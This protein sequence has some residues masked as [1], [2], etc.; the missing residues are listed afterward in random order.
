MAIFKRYKINN[1]KE[2][3]IDQ[4]SGQISDGGL[5]TV[6]I[7]EEFGGIV[8]NSILIGEVI[9]STLDTN[10]SISEINATTQQE[11]D[12]IVRLGKIP[13]RKYISI[14]DR[15]LGW[16]E[17]A[18]TRPSFFY[19][20]CEPTKFIRKKPVSEHFFDFSTFAFGTNI[21][22]GSSPMDRSDDHSIGALSLQ[23]IGTFDPNISN[24]MGV[25]GPRFNQMDLQLYMRMVI[26]NTITIGQGSIQNDQGESRP[27]KGWQPL[28]GVILENIQLLVSNKSENFDNKNNI[29]DSLGRY[30]SYFNRNILDGFKASNYFN[31]VTGFTDF[32]QSIGSCEETT[33]TSISTNTT[34][35]ITPIGDV[36]ETGYTEEWDFIIN[37]NKNQLEPI[38][39]RSEPVKPS[40][41]PKA[42]YDFEDINP[43]FGSD[44]DSFFTLGTLTRLSYQ[45]KGSLQGWKDPREPINDN[46]DSPMG[47]IH[48]GINQRTKGLVF[49]PA[50]LEE[51]IDPVIPFEIGPTRKSLSDIYRRN[52][53]RM[54]S[55]YENEYVDPKIGP[56]YGNKYLM[57]VIGYDSNGN[58]H[59]SDSKTF[60]EKLIF[61]SYNKSFENTIVF[62]LRDLQKLDKKPMYFGFFTKTLDFF[63][64]DLGKLQFDDTIYRDIADIPVTFASKSGKYQYSSLAEKTMLLGFY[65]KFPISG[66]EMGESVSIKNDSDKRIQYSGDKDELTP[67]PS[68][69]RDSFGRKVFSQLDDVYPTQSNK[70]DFNVDFMNVL[71][72]DIYKDDI[73]IK[74]V[75]IQNTTLLSR[76]TLNLSVPIVARRSELYGPNPLQ[77][78]LYADMINWNTNLVEYNI[79]ENIARWEPRLDYITK[80]FRR[81]VSQECNQFIVTEILE[82]GRISPMSD[83]YE[84]PVVVYSQDNGYWITIKDKTRISDVYFGLKEMHIKG[85][86]WKTILN[87]IDSHIRDSAFRID[88]T[89][90]PTGDTPISLYKR[91]NKRWSLVG[92]YKC[93]DPKLED[94]IKKLYENIV[95]SFENAW[96]FMVNSKYV[97]PEIQPPSLNESFNPEDIGSPSI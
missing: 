79:E 38:D 45:G 69:Q 93:S 58:P 65:E 53:S 62:T 33:I 83:R 52:V 85:Y 68:I 7:P 75:S 80:N 17:I 42:R 11:F 40:G 1:F 63:L 82:T 94:Q 60:R 77:N 9:E 19:E 32:G 73:T 23:P 76:Q 18:R 34:T 55:L 20:L 95:L 26:N 51:T 39:D 84:E 87:V 56:I 57:H 48:M 67:I 16:V 90:N 92:T 59:F 15:P 49:K 8:K 86:P 54:Y 13:V 30:G 14:I 78:L 6:T 25:F 88:Y 2:V 28:D 71:K 37:N 35:T 61:T 27:V 96:N 24:N 97:S 10:Y 66:R 70:V 21:I 89:R 46:L 29:P 41:L 72:N 43:N 91:S 31:G 64:K 3:L 4:P 22:V 44:P 36:T 81:T 74:N 5:S 50:I 47:T 12:Q